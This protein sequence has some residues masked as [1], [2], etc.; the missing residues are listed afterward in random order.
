MKKILYP[1]LFFSILS[2]ISACHDQPQKTD[3]TVEETVEEV[4]DVERI[5]ADMLYDGEIVYDSMTD[6]NLVDI[7][8]AILNNDKSELASRIQYP[9]YRV[10]PLKDI[11]DSTQ[12]M[13]YIDVIF[14]DSIKDVLRNMTV[15]SWDFHHSYKG[16]TFARGEYIWTRG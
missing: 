4:E 7:M 16:I 10:Y 9:V 3:E 1:S 14:D 5:T 11:K 6:K 13:N 8:L 15:S 12:M 2:I